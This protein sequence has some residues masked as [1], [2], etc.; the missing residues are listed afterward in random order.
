MAKVTGTK[1]ITN[2]VRLSFVHVLEP[3]AMEEGQ[4]KKYSCML[5]I[6]KTIKK[7]LKR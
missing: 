1:V 4:E 2:Q 7:P 5:I 6:Q 3:H